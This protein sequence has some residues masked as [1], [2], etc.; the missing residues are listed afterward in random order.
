[1]P[2]AVSIGWFDLWA[3][4]RLSLERNNFYTVW[5]IQK[6]YICSFSG[7]HK[8]S[9]FF[10]FIV[11]RKKVAPQIFKEKFQSGNL[12]RCRESTRDVGSG[13][14][15]AA[16]LEFQKSSD[17]PNKTELVANKNETLNL[18]TDKFL[19]WIEKCSQND[20]AFQ[21]RAEV[22]TL[23]GPLMHMYDVCI[24][25]NDGTTREAVW[26]LLLPIFLQLRKPNYSKE[27]FVFVVNSIAKWP[28]LIREMIRSNCS[29]NLSGIQSKAMALDEFVE[30]QIVRP[31]K[32]YFYRG[33]TLK[34]L[35]MISANLEIFTSTR[36]AYTS[37]ESFDIH[38]IKRHFEADPTFDQLKVA[39]WLMKRNLF[40]YDP[41]RT[42]V[43]V[44]QYAGAP[45]YEFLPSNLINILIQGKQKLKQSFKQRFFESY[46][47]C[48]LVEKKN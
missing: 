20:V 31:L 38:N 46:P 26:F 33:T 41:S 36:R 43:K 27:A 39:W 48:R 3:P 6:I 30:S 44:M 10:S 4:E 29:V 14:T 17:F 21:Y 25:Q 15:I 34:T 45:R 37:K 42:R 2:M 12:K 35:Q 32:A 7:I 23:W 24:R 1:M 5:E 40:H 9:T 22:A 19:D 8:Q 11:E 28:L 13:Y 47:E 18:L 16:L